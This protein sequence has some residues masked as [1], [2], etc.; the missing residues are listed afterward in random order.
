MEQLTINQFVLPYAVSLVISLT[1]GIRTYLKRDKIR[2]YYLGVLMLACAAN[3]IFYILEVTSTELTSKVLFFKLKY[4]GAVLLAPSLLLMTAKSTNYS[5]LMSPKVKYVLLLISAIFLII[6]FTNSYHFL[7]YREITIVDLNDTLRLSFEYGPVYWCY[8]TYLLVSVLFC[9]AL[10]IKTYKANNEVFSKQIK[11]TLLYILLL[12]IFF[13]FFLSNFQKW[14]L[15]PI[16]VLFTLL[17]LTFYAVMR[18]YYYITIFP[19][20]S[21][22]LFENY[23]ETILIFNQNGILLNFNNNYDNLIIK[24][25]NLIGSPVQE[26]LNDHLGK[27]LLDS[28]AKEKSENQFEFSDNTTGIIYDI[29]IKPLIEDK[30][31][32]AFIVLLH[33]ITAKKKIFNDNERKDKALRAVAKS[34]EMLLKQPNWSEAIT[35]GLENVGLAVDADRVFIFKNAVDYGKSGKFISQIFEWCQKGITPQIDNETLID[36]DMEMFPELLEELESNRPLCIIVETLKDELLKAHLESQDIKS[37]IMIPLIANGNLWGFVGFDDCTMG[38]EW[39]QSEFSILLSFASSISASIE[40]MQLEQELQ[41]AANKA[42]QANQMKSAFLSNMSHEIRTPLNAIIG[43]TSLLTNTIM[44]VHQIEYS[45]RLEESAHVLLQLVNDILD[46]SK[47]ESGKMEIH[48]EKID[49]FSFIY[50]IVNLVSNEAV[51]KNLELIVDI[52]PKTPKEFRGDRLR[53]TQILLNIL[54]NAVKFTHFGEIVMSVSPSNKDDSKLLFSV[55][56]TGIGILPEN[57]DKILNAFTQADSST[58]KKYG[59]TGLGL[60]ICNKLLSIM[61]SSLNI[62]SQVNVGSEFSFELPDAFTSSPMIYD[63]L[64]P[65]GA[66]TIL[67]HAGQNHLRESIRNLFSSFPMIEVDFFSDLNQLKKLTEN[68]PSLII[69]DIGKG[70][71]QNLQLEIQYLRSLILKNVPI[72]SCSSYNLPDETLQLFSCLGFKGHIKKPFKITD[73]LLLFDT[74][75]SSN[76]SSMRDLFKVQIKELSIQPET[77]ILIVEDDKTNLQLVEKLITKLYP[78]LQILKAVNGEDAI[79]KFKLGEPQIILMDI[80]MPIMNGYDAAYEIRKLSKTVYIIAISASVGLEDPVKY[81]LSGIN[82]YIGKPYLLESFN[83][84]ISKALIFISKKN[85]FEIQ[86]AN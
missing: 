74:N 43:Y 73:F 56:D 15:D 20:A 83:V 14:Q 38:R 39:R 63:E 82:D 2:N 72:T 45:K 28:F 27:I 67:F 80:H 47:I 86:S 62:S 66:F 85:E 4:I 77:K 76:I 5:R 26:I 50:Q 68:M 31:S 71:I 65:N 78:R 9:I 18:I 55:K 75:R 57:L 3:S 37:V 84:C 30:D 44:D 51:K 6:I 23:T 35:Y 42:E 61:N 13:F 53:L 25:D 48:F 34:S 70:I 69:L 19:I 32:K 81:K 21:Q 52:N 16:P 33:D 22:W 11:I 54:V 17:G 36:I 79:E 12:W 58:T 7:F 49:T 24:K 64:K 8:Q 41:N 60:S 59:G 46:F 10:L 40:R 29:Q 1:I